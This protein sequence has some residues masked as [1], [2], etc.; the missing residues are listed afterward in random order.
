MGQDRS[1]SEGLFERIEG[2][3]ALFGEVPRDTLS[4]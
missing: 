3:T 1:D 4:S 2:R